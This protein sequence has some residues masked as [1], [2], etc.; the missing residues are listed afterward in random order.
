METKAGCL[1]T[2][3]GLPEAIEIMKSG[4]YYTKMKQNNIIELLKI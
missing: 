2:V 1:G 3:A 4:F